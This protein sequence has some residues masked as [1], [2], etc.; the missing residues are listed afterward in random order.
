MNS[1]TCIPQY[2]IC[3][4]IRNCPLGDDE[5]H[6]VTIAPNEISANDI[7]YHDKGKLP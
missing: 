6:C 5:K 3:D 2:E 4:G 7:N 1:K